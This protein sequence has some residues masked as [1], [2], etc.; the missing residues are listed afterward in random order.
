MSRRFRS[1][2]TEIELAEAQLNNKPVLAFLLDPEAPWPPNR[3]DAMGGAPGGEEVRLRS[4]VGT[5]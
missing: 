5:N 4:L 2:S 3:V 1:A